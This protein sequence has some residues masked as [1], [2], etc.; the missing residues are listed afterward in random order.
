MR[1]RATRDQVTGHAT[2]EG[3]LA[4]LYAKSTYARSPSKRLP[5]LSW[6]SF[7]EPQG[8]VSGTQVFIHPLP[9]KNVF[10]VIEVDHRRLGKSKSVLENLVVTVSGPAFFWTVGETGVLGGTGV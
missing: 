8:F 7:Y 9:T 6:G 2:M 1:S 10:S 5:F 3:Q 4:A